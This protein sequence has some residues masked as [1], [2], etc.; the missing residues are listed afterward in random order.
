MG[1]RPTSDRVKEALFNI[2]GNSVLDC[3]FLDLFAGSGNIGIEALSRGAADVVFVEINGKVLHIIRE[4]LCVA[5]FAGKIR[6]IH[7]EVTTVLSRLGIENKLFD[8]IFLD[9]PYLKDYETGTLAG[10]VRHKLLQA[11]GMVVV[12]SNKNYRLPRNIEELEMVRQ[13]KY[14]DTFLSFYRYQVNA[15]EGN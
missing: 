1:V 15:G 6:L 10:I 9:P 4:N 12:E 7:G 13:E 5:G 3:N 11:D 8:I 14:G 2:L